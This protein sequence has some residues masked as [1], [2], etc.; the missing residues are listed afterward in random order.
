M[1]KPPKKSALAKYKDAVVARSGTQYVPAVIAAA[2]GHP[3]L[4]L[5]GLPLDAFITKVSEWDTRRYRQKLEEWSQTL[6]EHEVPI[7]EE[8]MK[9]DPDYAH[10]VL[11]QTLMAVRSHHRDKLGWLAML[12]KNYDAIVLAGVAEDFYDFQAIIADIGVRELQALLVLC[13]LEN[14]SNRPSRVI[15]TDD[16]TADQA[17][18]SDLDW[19]KEVWPRL[20]TS[21]IRSGIPREQ[22]TG[23]FD[24]LQRTGLFR[25]F[26]VWGDNK[27]HP[28]GYTTPTLDALVAAIKDHDAE[29]AANANKGGTS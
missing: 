11:T 4:G 12:L 8:R 20:E 25:Q 27:E 5:L 22:L 29:R 3:D 26:G 2:T 14:L 23:F 10:A 1:P 9:T 18:K 24:R 13:N 16:A 21:V 28:W 19:A 7:T 6:A 17:S 15:E